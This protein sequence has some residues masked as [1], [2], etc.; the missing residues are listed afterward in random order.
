MDAIL[1]TL[2]DIDKELG[3]NANLCVGGGLGL[4]LKQENLR[5]KKDARTLFSFDAMPAART[6]EDIDL[7]LRAEVVADAESML[8]IRQVLNRLSFEVVDSAQYMQFIRPMERGYVKVDLLV[9]PTDSFASRLKRDDRRV[10]PKGRS[11]ELHARRVD[12][13]VAIE[14]DPVILPIDGRLTSGARHS[15]AVRIP[16]AFSYLVMK[17][18]A[19]RDRCDDGDK[20]HGRHHALDVYRLVGLLTEEE[21]KD[22]RVLSEQHANDEPVTEVR[23]VVAEHFGDEDSLGALRI[24]EHNLYSSAMRLD[25][26]CAELQNLFRA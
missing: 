11:V 7:F 10:R 22:V 17:I 3:G 21:Y 5:K 20:D 23:R 25:A 24:R 6:T 19:F 9:G 13:A 12:E 2:L 15:T 16:Q 1:T 26:F 8:Q 4:Y 14:C 18:T